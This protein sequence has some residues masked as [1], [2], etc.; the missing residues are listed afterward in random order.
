[1]TGA[2]PFRIEVPDRTLERIRSRVAEYAWH[3]MPEDGGWAYGTNL[4]YMK[5]LCA[6]WLDEFDRR[7]QE[8]ELNRFSTSSNTA[9]IPSAR[10]GQSTSTQS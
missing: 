4:D 8:A 1:M 5:E 7:A 2:R 10:G 9:R 6:Y 3:E